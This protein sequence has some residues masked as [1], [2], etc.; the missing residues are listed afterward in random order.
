[1]ARVYADASALVKLAV[2]E[3][4]S[5]A[6]RRFLRERDADV[7]TSAVAC[8]EVGRAARRVGESERDVLSA[9]SLVEVGEAILTHAVALEPRSLR[10]LDAIHLAT[11]L[12]LREELDVFVAYDE[13]LLM[14]ASANGLVAVSFD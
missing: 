9:A 2:E 1:M 6:L 5:E 10:A 14:A 8:V 11:A 12:L 7:V 13:R 4:E 3:P